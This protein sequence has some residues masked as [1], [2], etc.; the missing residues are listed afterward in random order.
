MATVARHLSRA[1]AIG[2]SWC[3]RALPRFCAWSADPNVCSSVRPRRVQPWHCP[4]NARCALHFAVRRAMVLLVASA[5]GLMATARGINAPH[6]QIQISFLDQAPSRAAP[7][8]PKLSVRGS[9][10]SSQLNLNPKGSITGP[11]RREP[12]SLRSPAASTRRRRPVPRARRRWRRTVRFPA[13]ASTSSPRGLLRHR[14]WP[15]RSLASSPWRGVPRR[16][17]I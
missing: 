4:G 5:S 9:A 12:G 1:A 7:S 16:W 13:C 14:P 6:S 3:R 2:W 15:Q 17:K 11:K 10:E 8:G